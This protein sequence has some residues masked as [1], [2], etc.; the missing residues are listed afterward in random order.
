MNRISFSW[1]SVLTSSLLGAAVLATTASCGIEDGAVNESGD[2]AVTEATSAEALELR[3]HRA[4]EPVS[5]EYIVVLND[6]S[7]QGVQTAQVSAEL[8]KSVS[9]QMLFNYE[10]SIKGFAA[11][12]S[13]GDAKALL[14][15]PRVAYISE[16]GMVKVDATQSPATWGLDRIDQRNLPLDNSYTY[17]PDGTGVHAYIIDTGIRLTHS[18]FAGRMGAGFDAV[19]AGGNANDCNGHGTHVAGTVGGTTFGVAKGVTLH[20]VRVL[21]CNGSGSFAGVIA[22]IDW[23]TANGIRPAVANMSLG[24]G[25]NQATDDA[26]TRS[27]AAGITYA[28]AA[29]NSAADSCNFSPARTPNAITVGSTD[30]ADRV[31]SFSNQGACVDIFA[32]GSA[33]TSAWLTSDTATAVLSGTS[34][35]S[36]HVAG[37]AALR[38][39]VR[40]AA[41]PAAVT[42]RLVNVSTKDVLTGVLAPAPNRL[43]YN[44]VQ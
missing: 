35:A 12:M 39:Q 8:A 29:G 9:A 2:E 30:I 28:I 20:P 23:V 41:L 3:L 21:G 38:L 17:T 37:V 24:G 11:K 18:E 36:P 4:S 33:I 22:G 6:Q 31:S 27:I 34:M 7:I 1:S 14:A 15:D 5:G 25:V 32:P 43:L 19:T 10:N 40:P 44:V 13:E 16:N 26:V 42:R